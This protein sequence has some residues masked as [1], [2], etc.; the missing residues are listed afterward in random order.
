MASVLGHS[1]SSSTETSGEA[2]GF[3]AYSKLCGRIL[4]RRLFLLGLWGLRAQDVQAKCC[5]VAPAGCLV[6]L[7]CLYTDNGKENGNY[8]IRIELYWDYIGIL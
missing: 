2:L 4:L 3:A 8:Y 5:Q 6:G 7:F 1:T